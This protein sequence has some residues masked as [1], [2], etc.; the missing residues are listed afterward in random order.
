MSEAIELVT[1]I[2]NGQMSNINAFTRALGAL[3]GKWVKITLKERKSKRSL[4]QNAYYWGVVLPCFLP[5]L[6]EWGNESPTTEE[7]HE[8]IKYS[9]V[10]PEDCEKVL[11]LP[12]GEVRKARSTTYMDKGQFADFVARIQ[13]FAAQHNIYIPDPQEEMAHA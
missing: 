13:R 5:L 4:S 6:E 12:N 1:Q 7:A 10:F 3:N 2:N 8:L 11:R 9:A